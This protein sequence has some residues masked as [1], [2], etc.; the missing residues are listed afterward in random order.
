[1]TNLE[2]SL[3]IQKNNNYP[4]II[5]IL[6]M[7][8]FISA[9]LLF[10][11]FFGF[12]LTLFDILIF[13]LALIL[14]YHNWIIKFK[15]TIF[16]LASSLFIIVSTLAI[17]NSP[18]RVKAITGTLQY[19]FILFFLFPVIY[20]FL[21]FDLYRKYIKIS[22][23]VWYFLISLNLF[24]LFEPSMYYAQRFRGFFG[25]GAIAIILPFIINGICMEK[26]KKW[27]ILDLFGFLISIFFLLISGSRAPMIAL[28]FGIFIFFILTSNI[29]FNFL[30]KVIII[31]FLIILI[32]TIIS[33]YFPRSVFSRNFLEENVEGRIQQY[34][35]SYQLIP[36]VFFIGSGLHTSGELEELA[37][38]HR[39]HNFFINIFIETGFLGFISIVVI[40]YLCLGW[41]LKLFFVSLLKKK[42]VNGIVAATLSSGLILFLATQVSTAPV[43]RG[44][45]LFLALNLWMS[46]QKD[47]Y[48]KNE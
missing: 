36:D 44:L 47:F 35:I 48:F 34:I 16:Y 18:L 25:S 32:S 19:F 21:N 27:K 46:R 4:K 9:P 2:A 15:P 22:Y 30:K 23:R 31:I 42:K 39:P 1:M 17:V 6:G 3:T 8:S 13:I 29:S 37:E 14:I 7:F 38:H 10:L 40:I 12:N 20:N 33:P 28:F 11:K 5:F 26:K 41:G 24:F 45:W 43:H